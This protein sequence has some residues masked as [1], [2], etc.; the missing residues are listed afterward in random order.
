MKYIRPIDQCFFLHIFK[1]NNNIRWK[2]D[3]DEEKAKNEESKRREFATIRGLSFMIYRREKYFAVGCF[4]MQPFFFFWKAVSADG[5]LSISCFL[6][7]SQNVETMQI[8]SIRNHCLEIYE[9]K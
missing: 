2:E 6:T 9:R 4:A 8:P 5:W 1:H 3:E 7:V